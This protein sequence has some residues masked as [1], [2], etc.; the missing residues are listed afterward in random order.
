MVCTVINNPAVCEIRGVTHFFHAKSMSAA[1]IHCEFCAVYG[2][3]VMHEGSL[4][5]WCRIFKSGRTNV[6]DE[7]RSGE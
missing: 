2:Q 4:G 1:E 7:E 3:N 5:Q 6:H